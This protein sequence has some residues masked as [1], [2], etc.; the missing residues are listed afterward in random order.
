MTF[1]EL[2]EKLP[3][4][5]HDAKIHAI[6]VDFAGRRVVIRMGLLTG[7]PETESPEG[8][9]AATLTVQPAY[10]SFI[11]PPDASYPFMPQGRPLNVDGSPVTMAQGAAIDELLPILPK[12][13]TTFRFFL[14]EWNSFFYISGGGV[15]L[16]WDDG[17]EKS[18]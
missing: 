10:L 4:G 13:A 17:G 16:S 2:D 15:D 3:N 5:F 12:G 1:E 11:E 18:R 14:E 9:R 6:N 8:W 7:L